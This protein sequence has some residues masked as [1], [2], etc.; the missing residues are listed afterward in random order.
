MLCRVCRVL[1]RVLLTDTCFFQELHGLPDWMWHLR[2]VFGQNSASGAHTTWQRNYRP[3]DS[4]CQYDEVHRLGGW[5]YRGG[6]GVAS[7]PAEGAN[8]SASSVVWYLGR[9]GTMTARRQ[10]GDRTASVP[11]DDDCSDALPTVCREDVVLARWSATTF[12]PRN[13]SPHCQSSTSRGPLEAKQF[14]MPP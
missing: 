10:I 3:S 2:G 5:A 4:D 13:D 1:F 8:V 14:T 12:P 7:S 9:E 11:P 6:R